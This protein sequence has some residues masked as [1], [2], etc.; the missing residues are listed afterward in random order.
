[1]D[2]MSGAQTLHLTQ[3]PLIDRRCTTTR[4][5]LDFT[6]MKQPRPPKAM[7]MPRIICFRVPRLDPA[8]RLEMQDAH[9]LLFQERADVCEALFI[10]APMPSLVPQGPS[11]LGPR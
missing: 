11:L 6:P 4:L 10:C 8:A 9:Q 7:T 3:A 1:M 2:A 5:P